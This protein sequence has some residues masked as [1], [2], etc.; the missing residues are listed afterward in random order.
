[1]LVRSD[2]TGDHRFAHLLTSFSMSLSCPTTGVK[3]NGVWAYRWT[4]RP[5]NG[6]RSRSYTAARLRALRVEG[7]DLVEQKDM[8][9]SSGS[10]K[11]DPPVIE[12]AYAHNKVQDVEELHSTAERQ[13]TELLDLFG[14]A[15]R[16][17]RSPKSAAIRNTPVNVHKKLE[18]GEEEKKEGVF[19]KTSREEEDPEDRRNALTPPPDERYKFAHPALLPTLRHKSGPLLTADEEKELAFLVQRALQIDDL[20]RSFC[21]VFKRAATWSELAMIFKTD[22]VSLK[23][24]HH[25]GHQAKMT[26]LERNMRLVFSMALRYRPRGISLWDMVADGSA[27]LLRAIEKF[28]PEKGFKLSTYAHWW[29]K[30]GMKRALSERKRLV[31]SGLDAYDLY[32]MRCGLGC[33]QM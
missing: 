18:W 1:M 17:K 10:A 24:E 14:K 21:I 7:L 19:V 5:R 12:L 30:Q 3:P 29:I 4:G 22:E 33:R 11:A 9:T 25:V 15:K 27:G 8:V 31:K 6:V 20:K 16:R 13:L 28:D 32:G 26:M 2:V 23:Q